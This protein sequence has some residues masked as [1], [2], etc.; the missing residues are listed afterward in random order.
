MRGNIKLIIHLKQKL[1]ASEI[2]KKIFIAKF[3]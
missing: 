1:E 3:N 2:Y